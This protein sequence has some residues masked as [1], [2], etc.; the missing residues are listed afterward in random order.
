[1]K[2]KQL[3]HDYW[4]RERARQEALTLRDRRHRAN[5]R[6]S[7]GLLVVVL[8]LFSGGGTALHAVKDSGSDKPSNSEKPEATRRSVG[9]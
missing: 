5:I 8:G 2:R 4:A 3:T 1:M 7:A 6:L 9:R